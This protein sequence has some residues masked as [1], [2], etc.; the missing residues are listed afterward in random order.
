VVLPLLRERRFDLVDSV[1]G[2]S[3]TYYYV[4]QA[5]DVVGYMS[6]NDLGSPAQ[7]SVILYL[8]GSCNLYTQW[9]LARPDSI[10]RLGEWARAEVT[11]WLRERI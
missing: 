8:A 3:S 10:D 5:T 9:D 1:D 11:K 7:L 4:Y 2:D 6:F